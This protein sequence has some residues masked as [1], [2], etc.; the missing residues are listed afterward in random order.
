M[1]VSLEK[2]VS[3]SADAAR[4]ARDNPGAKVAVVVQA[5]APLAGHRASL[6]SA[7]FAGQRVYTSTGHPE[8]V[9]VAAQ[10]AAIGA[11]G[12]AATS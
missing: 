5:A 6:D 12:A 11:A 4:I 7:A 2:I 9:F 1:A 3:V 8:T 10:A